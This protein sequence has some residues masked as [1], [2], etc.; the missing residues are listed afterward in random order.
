M[1]ESI[2]ILLFL[3]I[4]LSSWAQEMKIIEDESCGCDI[5]LINGIETTKDGDLYGFRLENGTQI[6]PNI[7]RYV[8]RFHGGYCKVMLD[9]HQC[10]LID[11]TGRQVVPCIYDDVSYPSDGRVL[12]AK[13]GLLGYTDLNGHVAIPLQYRQ[14]GTF[15]EGCAPIAVIEDSF[16]FYTT[17]IDTTGRIL[18]P[19][20]FEDINPFRDGYAPV[21]LYD[22]WGLIDHS[23]CLVLPTRYEFMTEMD[24]TLFF[25]GDEEATALFDR[26]M[27]PLTPFAYT[28]SGTL[29][30]NRIPVLRNGKYGF[31]DRQGKEII[32]CIY[33][34]VGTFHLGRTMVNLGNRYGI[35]DTAGRTILPI[36]YENTTNHGAKY[37]FHD[38]LALIEKDGRF[39]F[40]DTDGNL[41]IP[42]YF[43][44]AYQ[45]SEGLAPVKHNGLWGYIDTKGDVFMP[46]VFNVASPYRYGRAEVVYLGETRNVNRQG[47][48]V[49]NCKGII[50]W[51]KLDQ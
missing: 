47:K 36:E 6:A 45:F 48:C 22:R 32:P 40:I 15:S 17:F 20:H 43:E 35:I 13:D 4:L 49:K 2:S 23:G 18:F 5:V 41:I 39:G 27:Q 8:D 14:A 46:F 21:K 42:F 25:A 28:W 26:R 33:D 19:D 30:D 50:S 12:V 11:S 37:I 24:D 9:I 10:G 44:D 3:S 29:S 51:R 7:Y 34:M 31:L 38:S 1:K 16:F